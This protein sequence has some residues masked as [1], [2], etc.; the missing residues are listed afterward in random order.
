MK[1]TY[2]TNQDIRDYMADHGV[3]QKMLSEKM[4]VSQF[5]IC[6]RLKKELTQNAKEDWL[7]IIDDIAWEANKE[8]AEEVLKDEPETL[9]EEVKETADVSVA[10]EFQIGDRVKI[11]SKANKIGTVTD[12]WHS[13]AK[14]SV[15]YAVEDEAGNLGLYAETQLEPAPIPIEYRWEA[16]ID[17][18][19]AVVTM[20]ATQGV[21]TWIYARGHAHIIHDGEVGMAQAISY[22]ARRMFEFL[23]KQQDSQIY[24]KQ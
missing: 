18:N 1:N 15:M 22:A 11:P 20:H 10:T 23:D 21:K 17:G 7:K 6:A 16:H 9:D 8:F 14:A 12:I 19:V 2:T 3:T 4:G 5:T 13:L 24:A